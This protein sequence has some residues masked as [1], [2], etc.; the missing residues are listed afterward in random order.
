MYTEKEKQQAINEAINIAK[1][2]TKEEKE[3][4]VEWCCAALKWNSTIIS[5]E[6]REASALVEAQYKAYLNTLKKIN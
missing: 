4:F 3:Q 5:K 2:G 1:N 6:A